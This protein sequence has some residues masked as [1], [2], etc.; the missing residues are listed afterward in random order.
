M[1]IDLRSDTVT[2]PSKGMLEDMMSAETGDDVFNE[3]PTVKKL[4]KRFAAILWTERGFL[5]RLKKQKKRPRRQG[6][7]LIVFPFV[8]LRDLARL[9]VRYCWVR[10]NS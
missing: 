7:I 8:F 2:R 4:E 3:D 6:D 5:M 1:I 10:K 9:L